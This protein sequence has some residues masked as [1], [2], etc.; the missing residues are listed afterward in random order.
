MKAIVMAG[1]EGTR[2]LPLTC[3]M[4]KPMATI[5]DKPMLV[6]TLEH[7]L[8]HG[9]YSAALT[10][11][12]LPGVVTDY[13]EQN[14]QRG[15]E[16]SYFV[17]D[18]PLGTAGSVKNAASFVDG[19]FLITSGDALT[20]IDLTQAAYAHSQ[21]GAMATIVL[22]RMGNP[23]G[24]GV[25]ITA[26]DGTVQRFVEKPGWED[27]FSDTVNTGLYILE[28]DVLEL[29][30]KGKKFDFAKDLF[31]LMMS[32]GMK[33]HGHVT[34]GYWCD[35]GSIDSYIR[36]HEDMLRGKVKAA[37][38]GHNIG[39]IWVG[40]GV[41]L[42]STALIQA[43]GFIGQGVT[44]GEGAKIG[45]YACIGAMSRIGAYASVKRCVLHGGAR[46]GRHARLT[47]CIVASGSAV[48]ER[49]SIHEG[50]VVGQCSELGR[51]SRVAPHVRIWPEKSVGLGASAND[52]IVF[53]GGER[54][55]LVGHAG[56][57]GDLG[58]D[59]TPLKLARL[60]GAVAEH[61]SG[62]A[63]AISAD[64]SAVCD[65]AQ[66]QAAGM[67]T[68]SGADVYT[69]RGVSRPVMALCAQ[70]LGAQLCLMLR[71]HKQK[72][73]A[74]L[75]EPELFL[76]GKTARKSIE[77][78][79]FNQGEML[80]N[81]ACGR[82]IGVGAADSFYL[83][84]LLQ[85]T[86]WSAIRTARTRVA[87]YGGRSV[88]DM[89][90]RVLLACGIGVVRP[91]STDSA[92]TVRSMGTDFGVRMSRDGAVSALYTPKGR[93]LEADECHMLW[94]YLV[95]SHFNKNS[96]KLPSSV[97]RG[98]TAIADIFGIAY[99]YA[100]QE[101]A[102]GDLSADQR[103]ILFDGF[104]AVCRLAEHIAR[105]GAT[106][107]E[108]AAMISPPHVKVKAVRCDYEDIGRVIGTLYARG[109]AH[110]AEGLR[111]DLGD[112]CSYICPHE[113]SPTILIRTEA[114]SEEYAQELCDSYA[115]IVRRIAQKKKPS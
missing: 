66:K 78:R 20:D 48:G 64:G 67:L 58:V 51:D 86:D 50:A 22:K 31:P 54:M 93:V 42:S 28:P 46:V 12:Y 60:F 13:F 35:V 9:I 23:Q 71:T 10:L 81:P 76:L 88:D 3:D 100:S 36:V 32:K 53:G 49:C 83:S 21:S 79:Y 105:T 106:M 18:V 57:V 92:E 102:L 95:F 25:V 5:L 59:L 62:K 108:L 19:T 101:E 111:L 73:Y 103:R 1:G 115:D 91:K 37:I 70:T 94:Y 98:V 14:P 38:L 40:D 11:G 52:N 2:L 15:C 72:L 104:F 112:G 85:K 99:T 113:S 87:L 7:L 33:I 6:Y 89:L 34:D 69:M 61:M 55:G 45:R 96:I 109:D 80:A 65:A 8:S 56:F 44:I 74:E 107:D 90:E 26:S 97:L 110:A 30:P 27:V 63:V 17:E 84:A 41:R 75:F 47:G 43:P 77:A 24:Y 39:G 114:N 29:I 82:E 16:L 4:P 68:L